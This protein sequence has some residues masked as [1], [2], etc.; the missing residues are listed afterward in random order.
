MVWGLRPAKAFE[1]RK[2]TERP[3]ATELPRKNTRRTKSRRT[4]CRVNTTGNRSGRLARGIK[5][6]T[7]LDVFA[8][9]IF[10]SVFLI[11]PYRLAA[12]KALLF[13]A[14]A[15][16]CVQYDA[17]YL[18]AN[19]GERRSAACSNRASLAALPGMAQLLRSAA[20]A[21]DDFARLESWHSN[22]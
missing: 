7:P 18:F 22:R 12:W 21:N 9:S 11:K 4:S 3:T 20:V 1:P 14:D 2:C 10:A 13:P 17:H 6:V 5:P 19:A 16:Y 15:L 8:F